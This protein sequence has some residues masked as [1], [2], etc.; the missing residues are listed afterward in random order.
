MLFV[1]VLQPF[2]QV[3]DMEPHTP[4][5]QLGV[6]RVDP[7]QETAPQLDALEHGLHT[8]LGL[9]QSAWSAYAPSP[10][11]KIIS[12]SW[13]FPT[14]FMVAVCDGLSYLIIPES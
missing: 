9:A 5:V 3:V 2:A 7:E 4:D 12:F 1:V 10:P 8:I 13:F 6:K 11:S 14:T